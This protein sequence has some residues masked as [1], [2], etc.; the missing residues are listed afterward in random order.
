MEW[1]IQV[2]IGEPAVSMVENDVSTRQNSSNRLH[3]SV[4]LSHSS[5]MRNANGKEADKD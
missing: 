2:I 5:L 4:I 3:L 1:L